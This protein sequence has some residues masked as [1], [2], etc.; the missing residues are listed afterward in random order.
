MKAILV[1]L[2]FA[3]YE[4]RAS[5]KDPGLTKCNPFDSGVLASAGTTAF[6]L[7][8][9]TLA[10]TRSA[11]DLGGALFGDGLLIVLLNVSFGLILSAAWT[12]FAR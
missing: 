4:R 8:G 6:E 7:T 3:L 10:L 11:Q 2:E 1:S 12:A 9:V 5:A